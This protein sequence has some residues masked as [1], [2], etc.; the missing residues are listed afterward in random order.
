[1]SE[2][3]M[4]AVPPEG[5]PSEK[6]MFATP[7]EGQ[8]DYLSKDHRDFLGK[9]LSHVDPLHQAMVETGL[10]GGSGMLAMPAAGI[11][12]L[13]SAIPYNLGITTTEPADVVRRI[14]GMGYEPRTA[15]GKLASLPIDTAMGWLTSGANKAG[16]VTTDVASGLGAPPGVAGALGA[17]VDTGVQMLP[18]IAMRGRGGIGRGA[19]ETAIGLDDIV[20]GAKR[21][22]SHVQG[23]GLDWNRLG[24]ETQTQLAQIA[25]RAGTLEGLDQTALARQ[26]KLASLPIPMEMATRGQ[27]ERDPV[28]L[29]NEANVSATKAGAPIR[30]V[31]V[32]Q[33]QNIMDNLQRLKAQTGAPVL[34][35]D[36]VVSREEVGRSVQDTA[37]RGKRALHDK[38]VGRLYDVAEKAGELQGNVSTRGL[39]DILQT[40]PDLSHLGFVRKWLDSRDVASRGET[41][42]ALKDL[43]L[44]ITIGEMERLRQRAVKQAM[45]G[46]TAGYDAGK[47]IQAID[48]ALDG[49]DGSGVGGAAYKAARAKFKAG[50]LEFTDQLA[51]DELVH[52]ATRTD[53]KVPLEKTWN[54]IAVVNSIEDMLKVKRSMLTGGSAATRTAGRQ[55]WRNLQAQTIQEI[56]NSAAE[57]VT[58]MESGT[59]AFTATGLNKAINRIGQDRLKILLGKDPAKVVNAILDASKTVM[60]KPAA[61]IAGSDTVAGALTFGE[62]VINRL[63][64]SAGVVGKGVGKVSPVLGSITANA[65]R[66][67][68]RAVE[69]ERV[70]RAAKEAPVTHT[71]SAADALNKAINARALESKIKRNAWLAAGTPQPW[72]GGARQQAEERLRKLAGE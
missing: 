6:N 14:A 31:Y 25:R 5:Q 21:A 17:A 12:G 56:I 68:A 58:T 60:T 67:A 27:L 65:I 8:P 40:E 66:S 15:A 22:R 41:G 30:N 26:L 44:K 53:R 62:E 13:L 24:S 3:N 23:L 4:F 11:A 71:A 34:A 69:N 16:N 39:V 63:N 2:Q 61:R 33:N 45:E 20:T 57:G 51:V 54:K 52:D 47:V 28:Q 19:A 49:P 72:G 48:K 46:G 70:A 10:R 37:L 42:P 32:G 1:M 43:R 7:P 9:V 35:G 50:K 64:I 29:R 59:P 38:E 36:A 55:A 18:A